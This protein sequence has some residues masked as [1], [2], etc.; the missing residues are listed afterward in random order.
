VRAGLLHVGAL[1]TFD[2]LRTLT[3]RIFIVL[4]SMDGIY[5][6]PTCGRGLKE[7]TSP[8]TPY[9]LRLVANFGPS[10]LWH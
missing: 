9:E 3:E 2:C 1:F 8:N 5:L 6:N 4:N 7:L 10:P